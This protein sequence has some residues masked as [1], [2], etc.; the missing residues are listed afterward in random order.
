MGYAVYLT[1]PARQDIE[2]LPTDIQ[3]RLETV[4]DAL[5]E[6]PRSPQVRKIVGADELYRLRLGPYRVVFMI[7][8]SPP[9]VTITMIRH[10]KD[11]YRLF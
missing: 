2:S 11:A 6:D 5:A 9:E 1:N 3:R 8:D 7:S 10:R 4:I